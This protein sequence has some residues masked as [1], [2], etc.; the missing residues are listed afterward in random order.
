MMLLLLLLLMVLQHELLLVQQL[1]ML[2][3]IAVRIG[4]RWVIDGLRCLGGIF[5][6]RR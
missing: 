3:D 4:V 5:K 6:R 1:M 2:A